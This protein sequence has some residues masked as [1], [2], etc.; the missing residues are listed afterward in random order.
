MG[1]F[2]V[3]DNRNPVNICGLGGYISLTE[4]LYAQKWFDAKPAT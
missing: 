2:V 1:V 3:S 4:Y